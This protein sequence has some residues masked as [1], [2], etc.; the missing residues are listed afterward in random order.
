MDKIKKQL[1]V[2]AVPINQNL[3]QINKLEKTIIF[4]VG[5]AVSSSATLSPCC[6]LS[7]AEASSSPPLAVQ[8]FKRRCSFLHA[9]QLDQSQQ[10][11]A[12]RLQGEQGVVTVGPVAAAWRR[13]S[14][15][16]MEDTVEALMCQL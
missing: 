4:I 14:K 16:G 12:G 9:A 1:S 7:G 10:G 8:P 5:F 2:D 11:V 3:E 6:Y 13:N 15:G